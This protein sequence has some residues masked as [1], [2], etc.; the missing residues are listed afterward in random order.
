VVLPNAAFYHNGAVKN[1]TANFDLIKA[2]DRTSA[3]INAAFQQLDPIAYDRYAALLDKLPEICKAMRISD[4][5]VFC[6]RGIL[7]NEQTNIHRD[8]QDLKDGWCAVVVFGEFEN[9]DLCL[10]DLSVRLH[11]RPGDIVF[12]RSFA[13]KHFVST[14]TGLKRYALVYFTY[15]AVFEALECI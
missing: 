5:S 13:L 3:Y 9:A 10:P 1:V 4:Q 8:I 12:F 15:Q 7:I 6:G 14:W 11:I 2:L